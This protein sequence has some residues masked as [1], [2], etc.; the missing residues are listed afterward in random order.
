MTKV[1][2]SNIVR[3]QLPEYIR[4]GEEYEKFMLFL[5][6]YYKFVQQTEDRDIEDLRDVD[7]SLDRF[8]QQFRKEFD[9][10]TSYTGNESLLIRNLKNLY[11]AKGSE[12]SFRLLF[13]LMFNKDVDVI[14]PG[15]SVLIPSDGKWKQDTSI[16]INVGSGDPLTTIGQDLTL[17]SYGASKTVFVDRAILLSNNV[18]QLFIDRNYYG[19]DIA[20]GSS[21]DSDFFTGEVLPTTIKAT[22]VDGGSNFKIGQLYDI[23]DGSGTGTRIKVT[24]VGT[25]GKLLAVQIIQFGMGYGDESFT[26]TV[27]DAQI[28]FSVGT[29]AKYPGH[30]TSNDGFISDAIHLQD[31]RYYQSYS[32]VIKIDEKLEAY[33][34]ALMKYIHPAGFALFG[35]YIVDNHFSLTANLV[36]S[37]E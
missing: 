7:K 14:Y 21:V 34:D 4:S 35:E 12:A 32:Y 9:F 37:I 8:I 2:V 19:G 31:S 20:I 25:N 15:D 3:S 30:F 29:I 23:I 26:S 33:K 36:S 16:F 11:N 10:T 17:S 28:S 13:K 6:A 27:G 22:I 1:S 5:E 24:R 18:Y